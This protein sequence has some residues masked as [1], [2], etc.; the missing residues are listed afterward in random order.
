MVRFHILLLALICM[1]STLRAEVKQFGDFQ[2]TSDS[3]AVIITGYTGKDGAVTIPE[4]IE[5]LP[6][7]VVG[8]SAFPQKRALTSVNVPASVKEIEAHVFNGCTSLTKVALSNGLSVIGQQAFSNCTALVGVTIPASVTEIGWGAFESCASLSNIHV[9]DGSSNFRSVD[10]VLL[11]FNKTRL[12]SYPGGKVGSRYSIP[13]GVNVV[14]NYAFAGNKHLT[15]L[16]IPTSVSLVDWRVFRGCVGLLD[17]KV[18]EGNSQYSSVDGVLFDSRRASLVAYP[19][20]RTGSYVIP[21]GVSEIKSSAFEGKA[22]SLTLPSG[23]T[24]VEDRFSECTSLR[25]IEVVKDNAGFR[26]V[27]GV[28]FNADMTTLIYCP[29][30]KEGFYAIP[31]SVT[32]IQKY[33]FADCAGLTRVTIPSGVSKIE[34]YAFQGR[35]QGC[36]ALLSIDVAK[37]NSHYSSVDGVLFNKEQTVLIQYP[38]GKVGNYVIP[39]G[40]ERIGN[41]AFSKSKGLSEITIPSG[42]RSF[43]FEAFSDCIG[44]HRVIIPDSV[45]SFSS[46]KVFS[47]CLEL[48]TIVFKGK[49]PETTLA[50]AYNSYNFSDTSSDFAIYFPPGAAGFTSPIWWGYPAKEGEPPAAPQLPSGPVSWTSNDGKSIKA[51]FVK[52]EGAAVVVRTED[53]K[54]RKVP[55][56][57]LSPASVAQA[58]VFGGAGK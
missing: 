19:G 29:R 11:D 58:K 52:L 49:A 18:A 51:S 17:I 10:G 30:G 38:T 32:T 12:I 31:A 53:G 42:V 24:N 34:D 40:V 26:S 46:G 5:N 13:E 7:K 56:S 41:L 54:E 50:P 2:Y 35:L 22:T 4:Q 6:V 8:R 36:T 1:P 28:L 57:R 25:D 23:V 55:F 39:V 43:G 16:I 44:L 15:H 45:S 47:G 37:E 21:E 27:D 3:S 14:G 20:G 9:E 33:A 48:A